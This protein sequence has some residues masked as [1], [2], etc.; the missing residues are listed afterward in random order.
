MSR[1]VPSLLALGL[2][3]SGLAAIGPAAAS[4]AAPVDP[5][6]SGG[7]AAPFARA[8]ASVPPR[9]VGRAAAR[10]TPAGGPLLTP[11]NPKCAKRKAEKKKPLCGGP[12]KD[13][14]R[15]K[16]W[17]APP[18]FRI[19]DM[20]IIGTMRMEA[21]SDDDMRFNGEGEVWLSARKG[22]G[23]KLALPKPRMNGI[24]IGS[25][26]AKPLDW[27]SRSTG[28]WITSVGDEH[29]CGVT[30][31]NGPMAPTGL[32]P[33]IATHPKK[34]EISVNWNLGGPA[35]RCPK[36]VVDPPPFDERFSDSGLIRYR[37]SAFRG[38]E[39]VRLPVAIRWSNESDTTRTT[40]EWSGHV[41][42]RRVR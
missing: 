10:A 30:L 22:F 40:V 21:L 33:L 23:G 6:L 32:A 16:W 1:T 4:A 41:L 25:A 18:T 7:L 14:A 26:V 11:T 13:Q 17:D 29:G 3:A 2:L 24:G 36:D 35:F 9:I 28:A 8:S 31:E 5:P 39:L 19:V 38:H 12:F 27:T 42:L 15:R 34:D 20:S 37:A